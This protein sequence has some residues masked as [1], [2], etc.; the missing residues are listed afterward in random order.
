MAG[1]FSITR[2]G[3]HAKL[4]EILARLAVA[5]LEPFVIWQDCANAAPSINR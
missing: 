5:D 4:D 1:R 2:G 3:W